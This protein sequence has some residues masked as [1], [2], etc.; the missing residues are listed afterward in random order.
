MCER[1][2][3]ASWQKYI[4]GNADFRSGSQLTWNHKTQ[5]INRSVSIKYLIFWKWHIASFD[6]GFK[7]RMLFLSIQGN[8][9]FANSAAVKINGARWTI[10]LGIQS[11]ALLR[12][13]RPLKWARIWI[14]PPN[15]FVAYHR[16]H[17]DIESFDRVSHFPPSW[18]CWRLV[19]SVS[20]AIQISF[21][22][23]NRNNIHQ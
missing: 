12:F 4:A 3:F 17:L 6:G 14:Q 16:I 7:V 10:R 22:H 8:L 19:R 5:S 15:L 23:T 11:A 20:T 1:N 2:R 9:R 21:T 18:F 13:F